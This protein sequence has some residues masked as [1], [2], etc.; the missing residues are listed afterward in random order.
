MKI[1]SK[2]NKKTELHKEHSGEKRGE[3]TD[4]GKWNA[5]GLQRTEQNVRRRRG[6][7]LDRKWGSSKDDEVMAFRALRPVASIF[8]ANELARCRLSE[9]KLI[10]SFVYFRGVPVVLRNCNSFSFLKWFTIGLLYCGMKIH[11]FFSFNSEYSS[12]S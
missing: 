5:L 12:F 7:D 3:D 2:W 9:Y 11:F 6:E 1:A 10:L 8:Q 4:L